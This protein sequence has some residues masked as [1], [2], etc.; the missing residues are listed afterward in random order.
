MRSAT[1]AAST[2]SSTRSDKAFISYAAQDNKS[3]NDQ[4]TPQIDLTE[5]NFTINDLILTNFT[6]SSILARTLVNNF[7]AG[8]QYW[9][10]LIDS[11]TRYTVLPV[12]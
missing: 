11:T 1:T 8:F 5:D 2:T 10:N 6:L 12:P 3:N 4:Y 9:N 7:T